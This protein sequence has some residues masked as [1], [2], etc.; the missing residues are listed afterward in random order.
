MAFLQIIIFSLFLLIQ[1]DVT[2]ENY[3]IGEWEWIKTQRNSRL[4]SKTIN[5]ES[6]N[7]TKSIKFTSEG[8]VQI[9][10]NDT[11]KSS[12]EYKINEYQIGESPVQYKLHSQK[13]DGF[14]AKYKEEGLM[15]GAFGACG[16]IHYYRSKKK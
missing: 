9:Y 14:I 1:V 6:C 12:S 8:I 3:V 4:G 15:I 16:D 13:L 2:M 5:K 10:E 7:C 11:L